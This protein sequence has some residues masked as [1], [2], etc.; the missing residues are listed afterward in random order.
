MATLAQTAPLQ[1][2]RRNL[3]KFRPAPVLITIWKS[4]G[5]PLASRMV[6][7]EITPSSVVEKIASNRLYWAPRSLT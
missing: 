6:D 1:I 4:A 2:L 7:S 3:E 5:L